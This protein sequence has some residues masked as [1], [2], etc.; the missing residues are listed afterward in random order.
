MSVKILFH[1]FLGGLPME[2]L[3]HQHLR[4]LIKVCHN[5]LDSNKIFKIHDKDTCM[6]M[7]IRYQV[8][9]PFFFVS[10]CRI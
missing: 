8:C 6:N 4:P 2:L 9:L 3:A 7:L 1:S 5:F 10:L